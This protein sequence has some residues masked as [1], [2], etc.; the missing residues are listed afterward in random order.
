MNTI[1][2]EMKQE[3]LIG[4]GA[5]CP[6]C[7]SEN[8]E[9]LNFE[10]ENEYVF[11]YVECLKCGEQWVDTYKLTDVHVEAEHEPITTHDNL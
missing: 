5:F 3:Y 6:F 10:V 11:G 7:R 4:H 8:I 9:G 2:D 1:T